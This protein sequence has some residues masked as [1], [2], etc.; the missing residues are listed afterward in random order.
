MMDRN[1]RIAKELVR[2]AKTLVTQ[3]K[4]NKIQENAQIAILNE[5]DSQ[6]FFKD[7][8]GRAIFERWLTGKGDWFKAPFG[9]Y[10]MKNDSLKTLM[11]SY[12]LYTLIPE[13]LKS[14]ENEAS[15][16]K[17][18]PIELDDNGYDTGYGLLH[19]TN[20]SVGNFQLHGKLTKFSDN[21][22][23]GDFKFWWCDK[24]DPNPKYLMDIIKSV[25]LHIMTLGSP[26]DYVITIKFES[27]FKA[28]KRKSIWVLTGGFPAND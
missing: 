10:L 9:D 19:G 25:G 22:I 23:N 14:G 1:V 27:K 28:I 3:K 18:I 26:E 21:E 6:H 7:K 8:E 20:A 24:I 5:L 17:S 4:T 12:I 2:I 15:V 11:D 16:N 13:F